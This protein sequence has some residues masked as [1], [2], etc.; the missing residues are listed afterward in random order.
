MRRRR[1]KGIGGGSS[2]LREEP[3]NP[4]DGVANLA[5]IMLVLSVGIMLAL[6]I[7]WNIDL[8]GLVSRME[9]AGD[10]GDTEV[11]EGRMQEIEVRVYQDTQTGK[12]YVVDEN[13]E[14]RDYE[15]PERNSE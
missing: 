6:V 12:Y 10:Q 2:N 5:D 15:E 3:I 13:G 4:L 14:L 8:T 1:T 9:S 7:N 11:D